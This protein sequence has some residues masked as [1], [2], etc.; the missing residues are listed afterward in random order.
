MRLGIYPALVADACKRYTLR[1]IEFEILLFGSE[2]EWISQDDVAGN[3]PGSKVTI[4]YA[5]ARLVDDG[6]LK[7]VRQSSMLMSRRYVITPKS[8]LVV[9][10]FYQKFNSLQ[11]K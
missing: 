6:Y 9:T 10:W 8:R 11:P 7:I 1:R 5:M 3:I 4:L 2:R